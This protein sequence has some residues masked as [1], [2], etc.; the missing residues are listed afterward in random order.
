MSVIK[1]IDGCNQTILH[2]SDEGHKKEQAT[3]HL[4]ITI[5]TLWFLFLAMKKCRVNQIVILY[6]AAF[7]HGYYISELLCFRQPQRMQYPSRILDSGLS[8][9]LQNARLWPMHT[10]YELS[11]NARHQLAWHIGAWGILSTVLRPKMLRTVCCT[12]VK[13][14]KENTAS[15]DLTRYNGMCTTKGKL[16]NKQ[17]VLFPKIMSMNLPK[18]WA[19]LFSFWLRALLPHHPVC[20]TQWPF[21]RYRILV[22]QYTNS[23]AHVIG[24]TKHETNHWTMAGFLKMS[25]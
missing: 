14:N 15:C 18:K 13:D 12:F 25:A 11:F 6:E 2:Q 3:L 17:F 24:L 10:L 20:K 21:H 8:V 5:L 7:L 23:H 4:Y 9:H 22:Y 19:W 16:L 1:E